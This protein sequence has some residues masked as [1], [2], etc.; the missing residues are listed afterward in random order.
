MKKILVPIDFS[1]ASRNAEEYAVSLAKT[2]DA[3]I[4]LLH[5][6]RE[7]LPVAAGPE[8]WSM[9]ITELHV[10]NEKLINKEVDYLKSK[11]SIDVKAN[12][13]MGAKGKTIN[14]FAK[15]IGSDLII[16]GIRSG[17]RNKILG[18]T[19]LHTIRKA[20]VPVLIIPG[21]AKYSPMKYIVIAVDFK[22]ML[23]GSYFD[24]LY[25]IYKKFDSSVCVL[26]IDQPAAELKATE[27]PEK[28]QLGI[29]LSRF[30]YQ[31]EKADSY[32]VDEAIQNYID[33]HPTDLLVLIAHHHTIYERIFE[34]IHTK[35]LSFKM[36]QPLLILKHQRTRQFPP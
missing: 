8:P 5:V 25:D 36:K 17:P 27:L 4:Q 20:I 1:G 31:Y 29:A 7:L 6:Y 35:A 22:E 21:E 11:Y 26:H 15:E 30:N 2:F 24:P 23:G 14:A 10:E 16:M 34:T 19:V 18:S 9:T 12:L 3:E 13:L 32:E 33:M 28:L